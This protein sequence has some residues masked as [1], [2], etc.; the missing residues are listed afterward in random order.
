MRP[1]DPTPRLV[2][3]TPLAIAL[4]IVGGDAAWAQNKPLSGLAPRGI[5]AATDRVPVLPAG[6][7]TLL[8]TT[9]GAIAAL[10]GVAPSLN[11]F[12]G[13]DPTGATDSTSGIQAAINTGQSLTCDGVYTISATLVANAA[14]NQGQMLMGSGPTDGAGSTTAGRC[15]FRPA[16]GMVGNVFLIDGTPFGGYIQ[17]LEIDNVTVDMANMSDA[18][19]NVAFAQVQAYDIRYAGD[20]VINYGSNK[21][22]WSF[23]A[24]SYTTLVQNSAGSIVSMQGVTLN[25]AATTITL[26]NDDIL[27]I[28]HSFYQ[29]VNVI[30]GAVQGPYQAGVTP[31][32]YLATA[33]PYAFLPNIGGIYIA[34]TSV[35]QNSANFSSNGADWEAAS[36]PPAT[37]GILNSSPWFG[38]WAFGTYNDGVHGCLPIIMV[39]EVAA[40]AKNTVFLNPQFAGE[41]LYDL[42]VNT[43]IRGISSALGADVHNGPEYELGSV[44]VA[45]DLFGFT[46]FPDLLNTNTSITYAVHGS[47]GKANFY[48]ETLRPPADGDQVLSVMTAAGLSI[49]DCATNAVQCA[50]NN[51]ATPGGLFELL[52]HPGMEPSHNGTGNGSASAEERWGDHHH[53]DRGERDG[54][55]FRWDQRDAGR[56]VDAVHGGLHHP[57]GDRRRNVG[58][59]YQ[60]DCGRCIRALGPRHSR[61]VACSPPRA[62]RVRASVRTAIFTT[63]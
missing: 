40:S 13:V 1:A 35:I 21:L 36:Q 39:I 17:G 20:R 10:G 59:R 53:T 32:T 25:N 63:G 56:R 5:L 58:R 37:C 61:A 6:A 18:A 3:G 33:S 26:L 19:T 51:G 23:S 30:G 55:L 12:A 54:D 34:V 60:L 28:A 29:N 27:S 38:Q 46:R 42:G 43:T 44:G 49:L 24:G 15:I 47:T 11:S 4:A 48:G 52:H 7:P 2:L 14:P 50:I 31:I 57:L 9:V 41:Y 62:T 22:S 8:A 45:G 16:A